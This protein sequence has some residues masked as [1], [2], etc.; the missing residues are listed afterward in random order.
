[1][2]LHRFFIKQPLAQTKEVSLEG[3]KLIHQLR[4]V[5]RLKTGERII[6]LDNSGFEFLSEIKL[7]S[8]KECICSVLEQKEIPFAP[9]RKVTLFL[10]LIKKQNFELV[11]EKATEL[12]VTEIVP[13]VTKFSQY[14]VLNIERA[15]VILR[16]ASEQSERGVLPVLRKLVKFEEI[17]GGPT[18]KPVNLIAFDFDGA[19]F[20]EHAGDIPDEVSVIIGPEGGFDESERELLKKNDISVYSLGSQVLRAETATIAIL[21]ILL[22]N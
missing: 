18:S 22:L 8:K 11:L 10:P 20:S 16:E 14:K 3:G 2:R 21:S 19:S 13:V 1:M 15:Q 17:L 12:G 9:K 5:F 4:D 7:L 6:L